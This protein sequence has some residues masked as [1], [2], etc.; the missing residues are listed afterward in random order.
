MSDFLYFCTAFLFFVANLIGRHQDLLPI[1][2][3]VWHQVILFGKAEEMAFNGYWDQ[4][5]RAFA[6]F[7]YLKKYSLGPQVHEHEHAMYWTPPEDCECMWM[8]MSEYWIPPEHPLSALECQWMSGNSPW[9]PIE[10]AWM[11]F[12]E[13]EHPMSVHDC[14]WVIIEHDSP[15]CDHEKDLICVRTEHALNASECACEQPLSAHECLW[16]S[17]SKV[18]MLTYRVANLTN[19]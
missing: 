16:V 12:S 7:K 19:L 8:P 17:I 3:Q 13:C 4:I 15:R 5:H 11:P 1:I 2:I 9:T 18:W 10:C 14:H 6:R